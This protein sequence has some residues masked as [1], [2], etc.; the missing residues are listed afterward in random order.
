MLVHS[1][2]ENR[3]S[4]GKKLLRVWHLQTMTHTPRE[5]ARFLW[6]PLL[7]QEWHRVPCSSQRIRAGPAKDARPAQRSRWDKDETSWSPEEPK[8]ADL[9]RCLS[10]F[11]A[12]WEFGTAFRCLATSR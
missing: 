4:T 10:A 5:G 12:R 2:R 6:L 8:S 11:P 9:G 1:Q 3:L 7:Q